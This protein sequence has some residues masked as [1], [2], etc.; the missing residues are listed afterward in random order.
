MLLM[1]MELRHF[2]EQVE[3]RSA[4]VEDIT[5]LEGLMVAYFSH[6]PIPTIPIEVGRFIARGRYN[7]SGKVFS[8]RIEITY[9]TNIS[10]IKPGRA[11]YSQQPGFYAVF[12]HS[13]SFSNTFSTVMAEIAMNHLKDLKLSR[14]YFTI[15]RWRV[16][17][18]LKVAILP[19]AQLC[20]EKNSF[21][22]EMSEGYE[23]LLN[24]R[25]GDHPANAYFIESLR[26][27]SEL[28]CQ[29]DDI[30]RCYR[31]CACFYNALLKILGNHKLTYGLNNGCVNFT[32]RALF[33]SGV[34]NFNALLP[35]TAPVFLNIELGL[36]NAAMITSPMFTNVK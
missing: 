36:R 17:S 4:S 19:F 22:R 7:E 25:H 29:Y 33:Y 34:L 24:D 5:A 31:I 12:P 18:E 9:N 23:K 14:E 26:Y 21:M 32:S 16:C 35:L 30:D 6:K 1:V 13:N 28:F 11:N 15:G 10:K 20:I 27:I 3:R 2:K 8:K